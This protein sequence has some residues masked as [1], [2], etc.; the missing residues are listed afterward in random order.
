MTEQLGG[1]FMDNPIWHLN[2]V[3]TVHSLGG[4]PMGESPAQGVVDPVSGQVWG[5]EGLHVVDGAVM[6]GPVGANP[7]ATIAAVADRFADAII[8]GRAPVRPRRSAGRPTDGV[9]PA[10]PMSGDP[11]F[12][13]VSLSFTEEMKGFFSFGERDYEQAY[14]DGK[15]HE[16][17]LM[18]HLTITAEDVKRFIADSGHLARAEGYVKCEALGA[19]LPVQRGLF[20]LFVDQDG[21]EAHRRMYYRL[22]FADGEGHP[23]TLTG[24]K[25]VE[26]DLGSDLWSD[27]STLF[28]TILAGHVEASADQ[29]AEE[30]GRGILHILPVDF[31][32]QMTTFRTHPAHRLDAIA[33]FGVL[34]A[35]ELWH[36]YG[37]RA[38]KGRAPA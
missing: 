29:E 34:F 32:R 9:A 12:G 33:R 4:C 3:I 37:R 26:D 11:R 28:A 15:R 30:A 16:R 10:P 18:F 23:L 38:G 6:P 1:T 7:S 20:N 8:N 21:D 17:R 22:H 35:G 13:A 14:R 2:R 31:A 5:Y 19:E 36:V 27:T 24:Y 25:I